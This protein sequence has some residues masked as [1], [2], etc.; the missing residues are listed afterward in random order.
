M[1]FADNEIPMTFHL[2]SGKFTLNGDLTA[3]WGGYDL[4]VPVGF[5]TDL[6]SIPRRLRGVVSQV[7]KH[8]LP[9]IFHDMAYSGAFGMTRSEADQMFLD[10]M[11]A[12]GV[13]WYRSR[14]MYYAVRA[15]GSFSWKGE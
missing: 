4:V 8:M 1:K 11:K 6:A 10:G 7:G 12:V 13:P 3:E 9:A 14:V 15:G 2:D 5:E